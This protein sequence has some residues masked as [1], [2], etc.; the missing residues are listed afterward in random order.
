M[1]VYLSEPIDQT[2]RERLAARFE[3]VD[4]FD[5]PEELDAVI[6]RSVAVP[7]DVIRRGER[8]K[9]IAVH[10]VGTD[11]VDMDAARE[12][13]VAV[14]TVPG[15]GTESVAELTVGMLLALSRKLK[16]ADR[17]LREGRFSRFGD[18]RLLGTEV[19]GK[20][21]G[22]VGAGSIAQRVA[23]IMRTAFCCETYCYHPR[24]TAEEL[25]ALG[26]R[27]AESLEALLARMDMVSVH[28]PLTAETRGMIGE[29]QFAAADPRLLFCNT[30]RGGVVD[31]GALYEALAHGKIRAAASDVF[32]TEPP[33]RD[34]P[35]LALDNFIG[36]FHVGVAT[37][38]ALA[39]LGG[40]VADIVIRALCPGEGEGL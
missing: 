26:L 32:Q 31:E 27:K 35:L 23:Q 2:A 3:L 29:K 30:A 33:D 37:E 38:D 5:R 8:L 16:L 17:G 28:V 24:R 7:G 40:A 34:T 1:K 12:R 14:R 6:T 21:L 19:F 11:S 15:A 36:T 22:V 25:A 39:R 10:G 9:V 13:G 18:P 4:S 20:K